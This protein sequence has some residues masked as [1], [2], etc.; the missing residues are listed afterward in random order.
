MVK[1]FKSIINL[2]GLEICDQYDY[3]KEA[4]EL[5]EKY[6][7]KFIDALIAS[8]KEIL[9]KKIII[10]SYDKDFDKLTVIRQEPK[11]AL[12]RNNLPY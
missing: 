10:V 12:M 3:L 8:N 1:A 6:S 7:V 9:E 11:E 4:V 2:R 5:W